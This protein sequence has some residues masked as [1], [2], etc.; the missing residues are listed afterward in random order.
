MPVSGSRT[1][2]RSALSPTRRGRATPQVEP[3]GR[4][5]DVLLDRVVDGPSASSALPGVNDSNQ[6]LS[7]MHDDAD[8]GLGAERPAEAVGASAG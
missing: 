7:P 8:D 5:D 1:S 3:V 4:V 6:P 2:T